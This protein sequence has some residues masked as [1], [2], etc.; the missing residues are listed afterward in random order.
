MQNWFIIGGVGFSNQNTNNQI[1]YFFLFPT[2]F[3]SSDKVSKCHIGYLSIDYR[4]SLEIFSVVI[5]HENK[6][7]TIFRLNME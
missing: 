1:S 3:F 6:E 4:K 5:F 7:K 2:F